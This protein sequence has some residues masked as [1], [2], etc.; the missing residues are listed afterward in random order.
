VAAGRSDRRRRALS[1]RIVLRNIQLEGRHGFFE[2]E[3]ETPQPF[4]VDVEL[5]LDLRPAGIDD[6]LAKTVDYGRVY[7]IVARIVETASFRLLEAIAEAIAAE[8]LALFPVD[9]VSVTVRKPA[10]Q[11]GG[12]LDHAAVEIRRRRSPA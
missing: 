11:L 4:E 12:P 9:E 3:R 5:F 8:L 7:E 6:D 1:D 10:V 2:H